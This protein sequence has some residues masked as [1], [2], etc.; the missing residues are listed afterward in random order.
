MNIEPS[1]FF[2]TAL[3]ML[4]LWAMANDAYSYRI[5]NVVNLSIILLFPIALLATNA[6]INWQNALLAFA[7]VF[8]IGFGLFVANIMGGGDVKM[9]AAI[10]LWLE[11]GKTLWDFFLIMAILG[12]ILTIFLIS[13]RK[14]A[15]FIALKMKRDAGK[16][17]QIFSHDQPVPYGLAIGIAFLWLLW[18]GNLAISYHG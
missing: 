12:G 10:A 8:A 18:T 9:L 17:P 13:T 1:L 2:P 5:P 11:Y 15:P 14:Y 7:I 3:T 16:I 6:P 4:V